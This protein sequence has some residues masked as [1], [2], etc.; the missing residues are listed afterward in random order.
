[1]SDPTPQQVLDL[2][3]AADHPSG[4]TTIR[5]YLMALLLEV[6]DK[7]DMFSG[8]RPFGMSSWPHDLY[9]PLAKAGYIDGTFDGDGFLD[10]VDTQT[11]DQ[12]ITAA[13][14]SMG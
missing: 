11:G 3:I 5:E 9:T 10:E 1:M 4:A 7:A 2:P 8:K 6:W 13:I 12:L 14:R